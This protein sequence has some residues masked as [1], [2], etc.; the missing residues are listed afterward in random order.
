MARLLIKNHSNGI[1]EKRWH[2]CDLR[3]E[4]FAHGAVGRPILRKTDHFSH[5]FGKKQ[6]QFVKSIWGFITIFQVSKCTK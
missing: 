5:D 4:L 2:L 3:K 6:N 1:Y